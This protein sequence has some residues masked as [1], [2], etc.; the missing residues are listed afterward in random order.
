MY[1]RLGDAVWCGCSA[2]SLTTCGGRPE[3]PRPL[4]KRT[5]AGL[6]NHDLAFLSRVL[7]SVDFTTPLGSLGLLL[8]RNFGVTPVLYG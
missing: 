8:S 6:A 4:A 5:G 3:A 2:L 1:V 7:S